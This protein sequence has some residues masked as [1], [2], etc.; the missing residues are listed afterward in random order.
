MTSIRNPQSEIRNGPLR[1]E[2]LK[3]AACGFGSLAFSG[4]R[5]WR[6]DRPSIT[7]LARNGSSS[8]SCTEGRRMSIPSTTTRAPETRRAKAA[9]RPGEEPR[10]GRHRHREA[11]GLALE[12]L[13]ARPVGLWVSD[14][15]P[16]VARHADDLCVIR[17][18]RAPAS[19]TAG[20]LHAPHRHGQF[21]ASLRRRVGQLRARRGEPRP[22]R[23][24]SISPS[25]SHGGPRNYGSAFLPARTRPRRSGRTASSIPRRTSGI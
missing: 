9:L 14:L 8:S 13:A 2:M 17:S 20:R 16:H 3:S 18:S 19:R 15:F 25:A 4:W 11:H 10:P 24:V 1:R 6:M 5:R 23:F 7:P 22:A 21:R 12:I